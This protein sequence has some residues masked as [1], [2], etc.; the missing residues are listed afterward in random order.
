[1]LET[2]KENASNRAAILVTHVWPMLKETVKGDSQMA[3]M[4]GVAPEDWFK[5]DITSRS[6][7]Y[8]RAKKDGRLAPVVAQSSLAV[9]SDSTAMRGEF[10]GLVQRSRL[11]L[12]NGFQ[13][14]RLSKLEMRKHDRTE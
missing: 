6:R 14:R 11:G 5:L 9:P 13:S 7:E 10:K 12:A 2:E 1:M 8:A 3:E 4:C